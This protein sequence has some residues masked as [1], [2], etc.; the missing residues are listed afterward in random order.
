MTT[1]K[2]GIR[3]IKEQFKN[4]I[5]E[6]FEKQGNPFYTT[7]TLWKDGISDP[8]DTMIKLGLAIST[9][10]NAQFEKNEYG[11]FRM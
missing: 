10:L 3:K 4:P 2:K 9:S 7:A 6:Q 5:M 1:L 8:L 11:V